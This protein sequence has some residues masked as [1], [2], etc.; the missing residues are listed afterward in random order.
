MKVDEEAARKALD[1]FREG[2]ITVL[3]LERKLGEA[4]V[5]YPSVIVS[6]WGLV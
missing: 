3:E 4:G 6:Q 2:K 1:E 5:E